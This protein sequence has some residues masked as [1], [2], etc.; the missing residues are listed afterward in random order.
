MPKKRTTHRTTVSR[1]T[2]KK[3]GWWAMLK[4]YLPGWAFWLGGFLTLGGFWLVWKSKTTVKVETKIVYPKGY[5]VYGIDVSRYQGD[6]NWELICNQGRINE[7]PVRFAFIKATEGADKVDPK[8]EY[9][10]QQARKYNIRRAAYHFY[11]FQSS[12]K[13]Q[14]DFFIKHVTMN[15][16]DLPPVLDVERRPAGISDEVFKWSIMEWLSIIE[17]HYGVPPILYTYYSFKTQYLDDVIFDRYPYWI[18]HYG[19]DEVAYKGPW[20]FWQFSDKG[21]VS[22]INGPVDLN[23]FNGLVDD[24]SK[25][26]KGGAK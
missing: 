15:D 22:G 11:S 16:G 25:M 20:H 4:T 6:I 12:P 1:R 26:Q 23:V 3:R 17:K 2:K 8:Y 14:A 18:A 13:A 19:V 7:Q 9:N 24:L 21:E 10:Y 5:T